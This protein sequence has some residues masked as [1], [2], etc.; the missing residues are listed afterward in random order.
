MGKY[1]DFL[2]YITPVK[3]RRC[4]NV[5]NNSGIITRYPGRSEKSD[6]R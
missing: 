4:S 3:F 6:I 2:A 5:I 1:M